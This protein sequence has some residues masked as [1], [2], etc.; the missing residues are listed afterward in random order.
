[1]EFLSKLNWSCVELTE[2]EQTRR[3]ILTEH[4]LTGNIG[5]IVHVGN[6]EGRVFIFLVY[7]NIQGRAIGNTF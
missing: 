6:V 2:N 4:E 5:E 7:T 1:M 3:V